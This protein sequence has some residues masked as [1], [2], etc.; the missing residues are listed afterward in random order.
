MFFEPR[1]R[2]ASCPIAPTRLWDSSPEDLSLASQRREELRA[3]EGEAG[4]DAAE[5]RFFS[6]SRFVGSLFSFFSL[7][8]SLASSAE[9]KMLSLSRAALSLA[10]ARLGASSRAAL[11][12]RVTA[13]YG[14][15][16]DAPSTRP[17]GGAGTAVHPAPPLPKREATLDKERE[18]EERRR[19]ARG[20]PDIDEEKLSG[21]PG[22]ESGPIERSLHSAKGKMKEAVGEYFFLCVVAADGEKRKETLTP[23]SSPFFF[24]LFSSLSLSLSPSLSLSLSLFLALSPSFSICLTLKQAPLPR[25]SRTP[26]RRKGRSAASSKRRAPSDRRCTKPSEAP[27][28]PRAPSARSSARTGPSEAPSRPR[29]RPVRSPGSR[30]RRKGGRRRR[31]ERRGEEVFSFLL[32]SFCSCRCAF[33]CFVLPV[34]YLCEKEREA[35]AFPPPGVQKMKSYA[36][37]TVARGGC[38]TKEEEE[39]EEE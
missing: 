5:E 7:C 13:G 22:A 33:V 15:G 29:R 3:S 8:F 34:F 19:H 16:D 24:L 30:S 1:P 9:E 18:R 10:A 6:S 17:G 4:R 14:T 31:A 12:I 38:V 26:S 39:E 23:T 32:S 27:S 37:V 11:A 25:R 36:G 2:C 20:G 35:S 28:R 21:D